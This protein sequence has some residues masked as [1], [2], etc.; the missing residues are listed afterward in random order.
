MLVTPSTPEDNRGIATWAAKELG[1]TFAEPFLSLG[2]Y[3][4]RRVIIG[5]IVLNNYDGHNVDMSGTGV[6]AFTPSVVRSIANYIFNELGCCRITLKTR[7]SNR[8]ARKLL[9]RHFVY[10]ATLKRGFGDEDALQ[11]RMCRDECPWLGAKNGQHPVTSHA[12]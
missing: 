3:D 12:A 10:E 4:A 2:V 1:V 9:G 8:K 6:G 5:A 11:F 7:R